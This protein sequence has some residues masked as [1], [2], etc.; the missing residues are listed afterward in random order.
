MVT[1]LQDK[2]EILCD[3]RMIIRRYPDGF[4]I[5][6][7]WSHG[8]IPQVS[9]HS[10]PLKA[11]TFLEKARENRLILLNDKK[12]IMKRI[13]PCL[14]RPLTTTDWW[15]KMLLLA[16]NISDEVSCYVLRFDK[17]GKAVDLLRQLTKN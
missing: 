8:D 1:L 7:T 3:D 16:E 4:K 15:M 11:I 9:A 14:V 10:A 13:L 12:E 5:Y 2:A 17:S 6:G